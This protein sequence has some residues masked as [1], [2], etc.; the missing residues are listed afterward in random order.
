MIDDE[1]KSILYSFLDKTNNI[2]KAIW[3]FIVYLPYDFKHITKEVFRFIKKAPFMFWDW[4]INTWT[5]LT[6]AFQNWDME[7]VAFKE[8]LV[9]IIGQTGR[10]IR[11]MMEKVKYLLVELQKLIGEMMQGFKG[12]R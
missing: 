12:W 10:G 4:V 1:D 5:W 3:N 7:L 2:L 11:M 6:E 9:V 8:Q